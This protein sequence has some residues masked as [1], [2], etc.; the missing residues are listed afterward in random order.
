MNKLGLINRGV[1]I[2]MAKHASNPGALVCEAHGLAASPALRPS[3]APASPDAG[4]AQSRLPGSP[5]P[6]PENWEWGVGTCE[7]WTISGGVDPEEI[8]YVSV[9]FHMGVDQ[10][11][12]CGM[13]DFSASLGHLG[14]GVGSSTLRQGL[15][16]R[17]DDHGMTSGETTQNDPMVPTKLEKLPLV[18]WGARLL[19]N[20]RLGIFVPPKAIVSREAAR[21]IQ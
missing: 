9:E 11:V 7:P 17:S 2:N 16:Q 10:K 14:G 15:I 6:P 13:R 20:P 3:P 18:N 8:R 4:G 12:L 19:I 1:H 21:E 5:V